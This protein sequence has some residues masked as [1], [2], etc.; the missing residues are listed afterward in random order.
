VTGRDETGWR[1]GLLLSG[2]VR[3]GRLVLAVSCLTQ[4]VCTSTFQSGRLRRYL[5]V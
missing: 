4:R 1:A 3:G 2:R 5:P